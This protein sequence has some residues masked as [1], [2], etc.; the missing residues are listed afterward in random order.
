M[1]TQD[2]AAS[3]PIFIVSHAR[4][5]STLLRY[6]MDAHPEV[7]CPPE[8]AL[9]RLCHALAYT[10][11]LTLAGDRGADTRPGGQSAV[12][13]AVRSHLDPIM[14]AY[15][16][17]RNKRRWCDKS[18]NNVEHLAVI[19]A[20]FPNAR[21]IC[22]H[23][24]C[25]DV[26]HSLI[27][28]FRY[29]FPGRY[30]QLVARSPD[31]VVDALID[32]WIEAA[33]ALLDFEASHAPRCFRLTY[34]DFVMNPAAMAERMFSFLELPFDVRI[35]DDVFSSPHEPGPGDLKIQHTSSILQGRIG[36][37][38]TIPRGQISE[39]RLL[40]M[41]TL[42][43]ALGYTQVGREGGVSFEQRLEVAARASRR[44]ERNQWG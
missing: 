43:G 14:G 5:G 19:D 32:S 7:C 28:L 27:E 30:G 29:G 40:E 10:L 24:Q 13:A 34:E 6:L 3:Q 33:R 16:A 23:R 8:L 38:S 36:K 17:A 4:T 39:H 11:G 25:L 20:V 31:N 42:H 37:G 2:A 9:G 1:D 18:S 12:H 21:Y 44:L 26:V 35:L 22:L 41:N 15:C